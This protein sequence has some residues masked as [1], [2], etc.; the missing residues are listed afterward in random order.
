M[1]LWKRGRRYWTQV[2]DQRRPDPATALPTR[3]NSRDNEVA[4]GH[5][6]REGTDPSRNRGQARRRTAPPSSCSTAIDEYLVAK[7]GN[8]EHKARDRI[9][10]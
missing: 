8:G 2:I 10:P 7:E 3:L 5:P 9:R 4:G 6:A 1:A